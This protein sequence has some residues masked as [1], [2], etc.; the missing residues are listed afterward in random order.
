MIDPVT[1]AA[2]IG[3]AS[4]LLGGFISGG[5]SKS[6]ARQQM[7]FQERM[8]N[9]QY[10]RGVEDLKAAGLNP[11]L[12]YMSGA[13]PSP[14]GASFQQPDPVTPAVSTAM[15]AK[16]LAADLDN[17]EAQT[18]KTNIDMITSSSQDEANRA[19]AD[20]FRADT[21]LTLNSAKNAALQSKI[22]ENDVSKSDVVRAAYDVA[23]PYVNSAKSSAVQPDAISD[24]LSRLVDK[25]YSNPPV[26]SSRR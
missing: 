8:A 18:R 5:A 25:L 26:H 6:S 19:L 4:S 24:Y 21:T 22:L 3:G 11:M 1:G 23:A 14:Q 17:I 15:Q 10:Q 2:L 12:A 16:R 20:K 9:T 7:A 13:A